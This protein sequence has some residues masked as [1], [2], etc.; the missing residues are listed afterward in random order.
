MK[1]QVGFALLV[2][3][4]LGVMAWA[5]S[6]TY[7][8]NRVILPTLTT[9]TVADSGEDEDEAEFL[10]P[11]T[12]GFVLIACNDD[13]GCFR[14]ADT[15]T[16]SVTGDRLV[17]AAPNSTYLVRFAIGTDRN[18]SSSPIYPNTVNFTCYSPSGWLEEVV[19]AAP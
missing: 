6:Q 17:V 18:L 1:R 3:S 13:D 14:N 8:S 2:L 16:C 11:T 19:E 9:I 4:L 12:G 7:S 5:T 10:L 15:L